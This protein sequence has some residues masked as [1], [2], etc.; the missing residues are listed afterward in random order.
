MTREP[1]R[2]DVEVGRDSRRGVRMVAGDHQ[3]AQ[4][5]R[6][7]VGDRGSRLRPRWV[8]DP[9]QA[10]IDELLLHR[11]VR[12]RL[13]IGSERPVR[14]RDRP[15]GQVTE[16][17]DRREDLASALVSERARPACDPFLR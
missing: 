15:Q 1:A 7:R 12:R 8:D 4:A 3:H 11:L 9:D 16:S 13:R 10:E 2:R 6:V 17:L 5:C 14:N